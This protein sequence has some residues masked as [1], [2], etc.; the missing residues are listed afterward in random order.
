[1]LTSEH[2][3]NNS[4]TE[5]SFTCRSLTGISRITSVNFQFFFHIPVT[6]FVKYFRAKFR[7]ILM[8]GSREIGIFP[9][10]LFCL[11]SQFFTLL[12]M[13]CI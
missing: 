11:Q 2:Y 8:G 12:H 6:C 9:R 13:H 5:G 7:K 4:L 1:M 10:K 3:F